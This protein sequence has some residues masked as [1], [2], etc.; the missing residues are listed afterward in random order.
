MQTARE[1]KVSFQQR[2]PLLE[3]IEYFVV[4]HSW[5]E[6]PICQSNSR[7]WSQYH[8]RQRMG[9]TAL[10]KSL[11]LFLKLHTNHYNRFRAKTAQ[12]DF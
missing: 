11:L 12:S 2:A 6:I 8:P 4:G 9:L 10:R 5:S 7:Q 1:L 3:P